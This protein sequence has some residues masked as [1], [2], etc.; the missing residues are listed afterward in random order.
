VFLPS[1]DES[2]EHK[3][4]ALLCGYTT[5]F[6]EEPLVFKSFSKQ[7]LWFL[8]V[9]VHGKIKIHVPALIIALGCTLILVTL[10]TL[11]LALHL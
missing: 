8:P 2:V 1:I 9:L 6:K 10:W 7:N 4:Y 5:L 11:G 3:C